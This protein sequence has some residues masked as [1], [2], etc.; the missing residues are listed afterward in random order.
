MAAQEIK[1]LPYDLISTKKISIKIMHSFFCSLPFAWVLARK[2]KRQSIMKL[3][4][5]T[6]CLDGKSKKRREDIDENPEQSQEEAWSDAQNP[7]AGNF[8]ELVEHC[9]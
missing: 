7:N 8:V 9:Q 2:Y 6:V 1:V 5:T 4:G 3:P